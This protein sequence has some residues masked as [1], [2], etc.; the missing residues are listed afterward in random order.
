MASG[1]LAQWSTARRARLSE[2]YAAHRAV[3]GAGRGRRT[4][5]AQLNWSIALSLASEF[6][7][8]VRD[9][10]DEASEIIINRIYVAAPAHESVLRNMLT[11]NRQ[12]NRGNAT[13]SNL[14]QDFGRFGFGVIDEVKGQYARGAAWLKA[15]EDLNTARNGIAHSDKAKIAKATDGSA[16]GL[17]HVKRWDGSMKALANA[18]DR[19]TADKLAALT[20]GGRPW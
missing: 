7:G 20:G 1:A 4:A 17:A 3:G 11:L 10:H 16:L 14:Q 6:Q 2:L 9:L 18:L 8:Y 13:G 19:I 12:L 5:T 15:L